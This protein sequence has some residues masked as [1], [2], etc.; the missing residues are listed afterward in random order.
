MNT[1]PEDRGFSPSTPGNGT[2]TRTQ[3]TALLNAPQSTEN[4]SS[5]G[6][7]SKSAPPKKS[8]VLHKVLWGV[9]VLILAA[10]VITYYF[11]FVAPY[12]STDDAFVAAH[13]VPMA[14]QV[15][16]RVLRLLVDDNQDV[17]AG[18][19]LVEIDPRDYQAALDL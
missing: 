8:K 7:D 5:I 17:K 1:T 3:N 18:D 10:A 16:G 4:L 14:P 2:D 12:E 11:I 6:N 19:L 9:V 13:T 15:A